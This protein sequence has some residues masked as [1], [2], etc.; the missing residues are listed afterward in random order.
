MNKSN[1][2]TAKKAPITQ[3]DNMRNIELSIIALSH[4]KG[5]VN[6]GKNSAVLFDVANHFS[7]KKETSTVKALRLDGT[8]RGLES[9]VFEAQTEPKARK[10]AL[11]DNYHD[12]T[13]FLKLILSKKT[14]LND[15]QKGQVKTIVKTAQVLRNGALSRYAHGEIGWLEMQ[16]RFNI[17]EAVT[18]SLTGN[19]TE[20]VS[21]T[22]PVEESASV[23]DME[24]FKAL[25]DGMNNF[26]DLSLAYE[27]IKAKMAEMSKIEAEKTQAA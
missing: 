25:V 5:L 3:D 21:V 10:I 13:K 7:N 8:L 9:K 12:Y 16:Q 6:V 14:E 26:D 4:F 22:A 24:N 23:T 18:E 1:V 27:I 20:A 17:T 11:H 2:V 19:D 15:N